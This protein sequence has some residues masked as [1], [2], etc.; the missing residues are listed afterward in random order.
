[1]RNGPVILAGLVALVL[2]GCSDSIVGAD[3]ELANPVL[4]KGGGGQ[5]PAAD[6]YPITV[7]FADRVG[8]RI[9]S[10]KELRPDLSD[11]S[12]A[13]GECGVWANIGNFDDARL[14]PDRDYRGKLA[15]TCGDSR[16]LVFD[17]KEP[18][19]DR[20][21]GIFM[22]IDGLFAMSVGQS[23]STTAQFNLCNTL[24]F[25][26]V[27]ATRTAAGSWLVTA[28]GPDA[29]AVCSGDGSLHNMPFELTITL[30]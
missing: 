17:F 7:T 2:V 22:N 23:T 21:D 15:R 1:M 20:A 30:Q 5:P 13:D 12:Y 10:D 11:H 8:D 4:K 19:S 9:R 27:E 26:G 6:Y 14:D 29:D 25:A 28:D 3:A 18:H 16:V 24:V